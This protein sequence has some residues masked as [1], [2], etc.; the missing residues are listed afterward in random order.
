MKGVIL[1]RVP[2]K[3]YRDTSKLDQLRKYSE[4]KNLLIIK[5]YQIP[6]GSE[7]ENEKQFN[8]VIEFIK[9]ENKRSGSAIAL[10]VDYMDILQRSF[11]ESDM[12]D[13]LRKLGVLEMYFREEDFA[14]RKDSPSPD[15]LRWD[16]GILCKH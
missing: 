11:R 16:F 13:E 10:V 2:T 9:D 14:I 12:V 5:D 7:A 6:T 8:E 1:T 4:Q 15:I 3:N